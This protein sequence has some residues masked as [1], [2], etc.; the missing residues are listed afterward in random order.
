MHRRLGVVAGFLQGLVAHNEIHGH[1]VHQIVDHHEFFALLGERSNAENFVAS[2]MRLAGQNR[3][4]RK[5]TALEFLV[6]DLDAVLREDAAVHGDKDRR[7]IQRTQARMHHFRH[8]LRDRR[9]ARNKQ[10]DTQNEKPPERFH[11]NS[12][13]CSSTRELPAMTNYQPGRTKIVLKCTLSTR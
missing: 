8:R 6:A 13:L 2:D 12:P 10:G 9:A 1:A 7:Q 11:L 5:R 4:R 3:G